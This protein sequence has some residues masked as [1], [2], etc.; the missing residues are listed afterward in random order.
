M[1]NLAVFQFESHE[2]RFVGTALDPWWVAADVCAALEHS[3]QSVCAFTNT[4]DT[5]KKTANDHI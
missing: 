2:V 5:T 4:L 3:N 1:S